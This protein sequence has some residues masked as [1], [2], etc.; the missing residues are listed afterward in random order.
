MTDTPYDDFIEENLDFY[1]DWF[2]SPTRRVDPYSGVVTS[3]VRNYIIRNSESNLDRFRTDRICVFTNTEYKTLDFDLNLPEHRYYINA[4]NKTAMSYFNNKNCSIEFLEWFKENR[5]NL[6]NFNSVQFIQFVSGKNKKWVKFLSKNMLTPKVLDDYNRYTNG[7]LII[8][9]DKILRKLG[10]KPRQIFNLNSLQRS[11][12]LEIFSTDE[13][14]NICPYC[15]IK[16]K[17]SIR[18]IRVNLSGELLERNHIYCNLK[19]YNLHQKTKEFR[20]ANPVS[21]ETSLLLS[22][23]M[24]K[25]IKTGKL[26][27]AVNAWCNKYIE[28]RCGKHRFRSTWEAFFYFFNQT[29]K[30]LQYE[31]LRIPYSFKG[32]EHMYIV[33]FIDYSD[34]IIYEIKPKSMTLTNRNKVKFSAAEKWANRNKYRFAL[35]DDSWFHDHVTTTS[36]K[37]FYKFV[38]LTERTINNRM[39]HFNGNV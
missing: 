15:N 22:Q 9:R 25:S 8:F 7:R 31:K 11:D 18:N 13:L 36:L 20:E 14:T 29:T 4:S 38:D 27:P 5:S 16:N 3:R 34:N 10:G 30:S 17:Y 32:N 24:K 2:S 12:V 21:A 33:D 39:G 37:D 26:Q 1:K 28:S 23:N 19:C 6:K 35:I